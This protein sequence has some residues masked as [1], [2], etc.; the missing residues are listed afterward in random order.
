MKSNFKENLRIIW[1]IM[2]KDLI[3][4]IKNKNVISL[5]ISSLFIV[6]IYK[7]LP[8]LTADDGPPAV[9]LYEAGESQ[10]VADL[11]DS[12][13]VNLYT[14]E[15]EEDMKYYLSNGEVPELGLLVPAD[16]D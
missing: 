2:S 3:D 16:V 4:A 9:L 5:L 15:S 14:Y 13:A 6:L 8:A 12:P 7:Y 11:W 1:A 10:F